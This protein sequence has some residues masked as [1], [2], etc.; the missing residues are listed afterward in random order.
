[1]SKLSNRRMSLLATQETKLQDANRMVES[2]IMLEA[3]KLRD[4][5]TPR[6]FVNYERVTADL[7]N[8]GYLDV[9]FSYFNFNLASPYFKKIKEAAQKGPL[10][11]KMLERKVMLITKPGA[12]GIVE[13][14]PREGYILDEIAN[15]LEEYDIGLIPNPSQTTAINPFRLFIL[16]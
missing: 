1:M 3:K 2:E 7:L 14:E 6:M 12:T 5:I 13:I 8:T 15:H 4:E 10:L 11:E 16:E 9:S